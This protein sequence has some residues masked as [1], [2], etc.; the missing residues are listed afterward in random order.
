MR[1]FHAAVI[2]ALLFHAA[3]PASVFGVQETSGT[4][5]VEG[6][7]IRSDTGE[8][9]QGARVTLSLAPPPAAPR[10][11]PG[12]A[13]SVLIGERSL[14]APGL[15]STITSSAPA[16]APSAAPSPVS[17]IRD[18]V[19]DR[20]GS[21]VFTDLQ[22]G[23]Y[24]L[25]VAGNGYVPHEYG[26]TNRFRPVHPL[27]LAADQPVTGLGIR[28][29]PTGTVSGR[30]LDLAGQPLAGVPVHIY[31]FAYAPTGEWN[32]SIVATV[33]TNDRG[34]Y[35]IFW[36]APGRHYVMAGGNAAVGRSVNSNNNDIL[37]NYS[38]A[39]CPHGDDIRNAG[40][41]DVRPGS[42]LSGCDFRV[43]P[44]SLYRISGKVVDSR[45]G[46]PPSG[47]GVSVESW[48]P[49]GTR[50]NSPRVYYDASNGTFEAAD[51]APGTYNLTSSLTER[52]TAPGPR[53]P[54][55]ALS[56]AAIVRVVNSDV[57]DVVLSVAPSPG[58]SG[59][60][61]AEGQLPPGTRLQ[62]RLVPAN[63]L[64][65][66]AQV[67]ASVNSDGTF[68]FQAGSFRNGPGDYRVSMASITAQSGLPAG[69]YLKEARLGDTDVLNTPAQFPSDRPLTVYLSSKG[70]QIAGVARAEGQQRA[71]A[72]TAVLVPDGNR[73]RLDLFQQSIADPTGRFNFANVPPGSYKV[74]A[75]EG[76]D[77]YSWFDPE[78]LKDFE[79]R[80]VAV[81]ITEGARETLDLRSIPQG[82][83]Q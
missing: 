83:A 75:W 28:L 35:R 65:G 41:V 11:T 22:A 72:V 48:L 38:Y 15:P 23:A 21:F 2:C 27:V 54:F 67:T 58:V 12:E 20:D 55:G 50:G 63:S 64:F 19:T 13:G 62:V 43:A 14:G 17:S 60:V 31:R 24:R 26:Q 39:F 71:A 25:N 49:I 80:G 46:Q 33:R 30:V 42:E 77:S 51:V 47:G 6:K 82:S 34:E 4:A 10:G 53:P 78:W 5:R 37:D 36:I 81:R 52:Q 69:W 45:T 70:G 66:P 57:R 18:A 32:P 3:V 76:I 68:G 56:T 8:P 59:Q 61:I 79:Q 9:I 44:Q 40:V 29:I 16:A 73:A 7:V 74:F 1:F